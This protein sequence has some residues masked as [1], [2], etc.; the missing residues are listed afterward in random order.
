MTKIPKDYLKY[1][2]VIFY[3]YKRK[4]NL[5]QAELDVLLFLYSES[6]FDCVKIKEIEGILPWDKTRIAKLKK[7]G[8]IDTFREDKKSK[9]LYVLSKKSKN[10]VNG[11]YEKLNGARVPMTYDNNPMYAKD[12]PYT[13]KV[14]K[15]MI[16]R[17]NEARKL[18]PHQLPEL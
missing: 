18:Q 17:M 12:V 8:F 10:I 5:S 11:I 2:R 7:E 16:K 1:Y 9:R 13:D 14:Y 3:F 4:F 15:Q 6:Y